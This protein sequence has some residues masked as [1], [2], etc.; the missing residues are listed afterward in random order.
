MMR[1]VLQRR[2]TRALKEQAD[3]HR[4]PTGPTWC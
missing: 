4:P 3:G 2:F 1:E